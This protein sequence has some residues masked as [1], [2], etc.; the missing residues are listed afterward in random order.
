MRPEIPAKSLQRG[1]RSALANPHPPPDRIDAGVAKDPLGKTGLGGCGKSQG[2][3]DVI[4]HPRPPSVPARRKP[5]FEKGYRVNFGLIFAGHPELLLG[6]GPPSAGLFIARKSWWFASGSGSNR[7]G[8]RRTRFP[9]KPPQSRDG[10]SLFSFS[11]DRGG[12]FFLLDGR[13]H[14]FRTGTQEASA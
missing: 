14:D 9:G 7:A 3:P 1:L 2:R 10:F 12:G 8:G 13:L 4:F 5:I 11:L 6:G